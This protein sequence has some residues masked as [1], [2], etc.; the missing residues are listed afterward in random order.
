MVLMSSIVGFQGMPF[1]A[2]YAATK[3]YVQTLAEALSV[4]LARLGV[5]VIASAPGPINSGFADRAGMKMGQVLHPREVAQATLNLPF[6]RVKPMTPG[7]ST[8]SPSTCQRAVQS[9]GM[10]VIPTIRRK[11]ISRRRM[12]FLSRLPANA[13]P[14]AR[15]HPGSLIT[16]KV[17]VTILKQCLVASPLGFLNPSMV[18]AWMDFC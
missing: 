16:S 6:Y 14:S 13:I 9:M 17:L 12:P 18:T 1:A 11:M 7:D 2:H 10:L 3:A 15:M 8:P 4:E 5:D